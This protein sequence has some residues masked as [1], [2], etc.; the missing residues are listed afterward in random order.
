MKRFALMSL[1]LLLL[2][3]QGCATKTYGR[4]EAMTPYERH[5][6]SC[7][8]IDLETAKVQA[9]VDRV[10][11][12]SRFSG[13]DLVALL[14]DFGIGNKLER[15]AALKSATLRL[16]QLRELREAERCSSEPL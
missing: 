13:L 11:E 6:L 1:A 16:E 2:T 7:Q 5:H 12:E 3:I 10:N 9:F 15:D 8:Q 4:Q 14:V